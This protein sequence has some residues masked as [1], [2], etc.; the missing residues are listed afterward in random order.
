MPKVHHVLVGVAAATIVA[1]GAVSAQQSDK[2]KRR[3]H[4]THD[5][6]FDD[7]VAPG[8]EGKIGD[9]V[10]T[11]VRIVVRPDGSRMA[12]LDE[13]FHDAIVATRNADGTIGYACLH[14]VPVAN[15]LVTTPLPAPA[16]PVLE[17]K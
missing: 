7:A 10:M 9:R 4:Q 13:S 12:T 2:A 17:E 8:Q 15:R 5:K 6:G 1:V 3:P 14:G 16:T 11:G